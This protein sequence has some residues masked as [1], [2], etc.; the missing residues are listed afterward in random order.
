MS[1]PTSDIIS[2]LI[3][4]RLA[5]ADRDKGETR[6]AASKD[7]WPLFER[8]TKAE[9]GR[10]FEEKASGLV[11]NGLAARLGRARYG[12]TDAGES[13]ALKFLG[14]AE[15][16]VRT[17]WEPVKNRLLMAQALALNP[18]STKVQ[19]HLKKSDGLRACI[20]KQRHKLPT[21]ELPTATQ[22]MDL[23]A[24]QAVGAR[25]SGAIE[26]R[27]AL[28]RQW[29]NGLAHSTPEQ[30]PATAQT[31]TDEKQAFSTEVLA[32][33]RACDT[34][35]FGDYKVFIAHV[36]R[37]LYASGSAYA[38]D[39]RQFKQR[40]VEANRA[41]HLRHDPL[42]VPSVHEEARQAFAS[43][44]NKVGA[45]LPYGKILLL[46]GE[47]GSGK[48]HLMRAF[49]SEVT[50]TAS[51]YF[52]YMQ[53]TSSETNYAQ[54]VLTNVIDSLHQ[55]YDEA[56][57][58]SSGLMRL[59]NGLVEDP[60]LFDPPALEY[61][62]DGE[63]DLP[64][65]FDCSD[66]LIGTL[67]LQN[68]NPDLLRVLLLLQR[69]EPHLKNLVL[70]YLRCHDLSHH[71][72]QKLGDIRPLRDASGPRE[73]IKSLAG[74][75]WALEKTPFVL[76]LDQ[77]EDIYELN[78]PTQERF[79]A[80]M[81]V[82]REVADAVPSLIVVI[83]CLEDFYQKLKTS[84]TSPLLDRIEKDP[85]PVKLSNL[86]SAAEVEQLIIRRL[87]FLFAECEAPFTDE[88]PLFPFAA[89]VRQKLAGF[90]ARVVLELC[91]QARERSLA[92]GQRPEI[93][94]RLCRPSL[95]PRSRSNSAGTTFTP[96]SN[97]R[98]RSVKQQ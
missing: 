76:C 23:L 80:A 81:R 40:L 64:R 73:V 88:Q 97:R 3:L 26:L 8:M 30:R 66:H 25:R 15:L 37:K 78:A 71:D 1:A 13:A 79:L 86:R 24:G 69:S 18:S 45:G 12:V 38:V 60:D 19:A 50:S 58:E 93:Q 17:K 65:V 36:W 4:A 91:R 74:L 92:S 42:D 11:E 87:Q 90:R 44:L 98:R 48:T 70:Q 67:G 2:N 34:G 49:R 43:L 41:G 83:A 14:V 89:D 84:L 82:V 20:L 21:G 5:L 29:I 6:S 16:P 68:L 46:L 39:E 94:N 77:L 63:L 53:M 55:P 33:A 31:P 52:A 96:P 32:V 62:R 35:R 22:V 85:E 47:A 72:Q 59:S 61:L 57:S 28:L 56:V 9:W 27:Q 10:V 7:V 54:Y 95:I 75:A 51:G